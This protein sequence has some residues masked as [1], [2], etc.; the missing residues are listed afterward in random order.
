MLIALTGLHAAGKTY[1]SSNIPPKYGF[2]VYSKKDI[3]KLLCKESTGRDDWQQWYR[4]EFNRNAYQVT[5]KILS[6]LNLQDKIILDGEE[7]LS[8]K[9]IKIKGIHNYENIM[10]SIWIAKK[11]GVTNEQIQEYFKSFPGVEHRIEFVR[12]LHGRSFYNDS[13]ATNNE[14]TKIALDSFTSDTLLLMGGLDR[15]IPFEELKSHLN[16][17]KKIFC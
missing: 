8:S 5:S 9:D 1:F 10:A 13:K 6:Y 3:I 2:L 15:G 4:E 12:E 11:F 17:V 7:T 14:A 16:H